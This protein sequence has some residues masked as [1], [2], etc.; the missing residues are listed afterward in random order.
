MQRVELLASTGI[1]LDGQRI[2]DDL[3]D[4]AVAA[5]SATRYARGEAV[6]LPDGHLDR[7]GCI[8]R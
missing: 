8:W 6:S 2:D 4:A 1:H 5:W 3:L 7:L